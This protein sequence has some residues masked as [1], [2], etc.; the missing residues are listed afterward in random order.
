MRRGLV[1]LL[2]GWALLAAFVVAI[3][4]GVAKDNPLV[5]GA[6]T[7]FPEEVDTT[8]YF[9]LLSISDFPINTQ[10]PDPQWTQT[11]FWGVTTSTASCVGSVIGTNTVGLQQE[12]HT[13][14]GYSSP[15]F[16]E[17]DFVENGRPRTHPERGLAVPVVVARYPTPV[18]T[19]YLIDHQNQG[20]ANLPNA[21]LP[22]V[23]VQVTVRAGDSISIDDVAYD[24]GPVLMEGRTEPA[25]LV[26]G[27]AYGITGQPSSQVRGSQVGSSFVYEFR[28][29]LEVLMDTIPAGTGFNL[30]IDAFVDNP[31]C[32]EPME[33]GAIMPNSLDAFLD[34]DHLPNL[35]V[36][37]SPALVP[38]YGP[39]TV[40]LDGE[41]GRQLV[42]HW[43]A[44]SPWGNYD[45]DVTKARLQVYGPADH[46]F[47]LESVVQ[48]TRE[49]YHHFDAPSLAW[50]WNLDEHPA[51]DG[52]YTAVLTM[53]NLQ[54]TARAEG[55][56]QFHIADG[57]LSASGAQQLPAPPMAW[58]VLCIATA[59]LLAAR[60]PQA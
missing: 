40:L 3:P 6:T 29:P 35:H 14:R 38:A 50:V 44:N 37:N 26:A 19:W 8:L 52:L 59:G 49:A 10:K 9:H 11:A 24:T 31:L 51:A 30:R 33:T 5:Q 2:V 57:R 34:A 22:N 39:D 60:R 46:S 53:P 21:P 25:T 13:W 45:V 7:V 1:G 55:V 43:S 41:N 28:V 12:Y 20:A 15:S 27:Q 56:V 36:R 16:V 17:Y 23:V 42:L 18:V 58:M 54:G 32:D 48:R 4:A 47:A